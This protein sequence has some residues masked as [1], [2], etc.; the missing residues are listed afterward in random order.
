MTIAIAACL[1]ERLHAGGGVAAL[2]CAYEFGAAEKAFC[3][4]VFEQ[5]Q[6]PP[7]VESE[8]WFVAMVL[9]LTHAMYRHIRPE[10][11]FPYAL[12]HGRVVAGL[13]L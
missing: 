2:D 8:G 12:W 7:G 6:E 4:L 1:L 10:D 3:G 13:C 9:D 11:G 5:M